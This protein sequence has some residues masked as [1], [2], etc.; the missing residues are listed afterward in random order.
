MTNK[1]ASW[2]T[3]WMG[4]ADIVAKRSR[5]SRAQIGAVI[6]DTNSRISAT[7]YNGP[8]ATLK[9]EGECL[10]WCERAQG[11]TGLGSSYEG[12]PSIHAE[13]NA[14]LYVD[15]SRI[16][17]GTIYVTGAPCMQCAKLISNSGLKRVVARVKDSDAHRNPEV[18]LDYL[19]NCDILVETIKDD[20][21]DEP[22]KYTLG[23]NR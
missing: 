1:V 20:I 3:T 16:E 12:C 21:N 15:R 7:G 14:L 19:V 17:G 11:K 6:V 22:T 13:A 9:V 5:C 4:V 8:S 10:N 2:D 23:A 18:V